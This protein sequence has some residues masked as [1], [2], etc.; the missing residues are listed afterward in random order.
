MTDSFHAPSFSYTS[1]TVEMP[2]VGQKI[3]TKMRKPKR[4]C[5]LCDKQYSTMH[6]YQK[7]IQMEHKICQ[8][9]D[10]VRCGFCGSVFTDR[11]SYLAHERASL[12]KVEMAETRCNQGNVIF[13]DP[14]QMLVGNDQYQ[15][16]QQ[17][18]QQPEQDQHQSHQE[19]SSYNMYGE[20]GDDDD[21]D[22]LI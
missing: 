14:R 11:E 6:Y 1:A 12:A 17:Q 21:T 13:V 5:F 19:G 7:H 18:Q 22:S 16:E 20:Q 8:R 3:K 10:Q 2:S 15:Q 4:A 9:V